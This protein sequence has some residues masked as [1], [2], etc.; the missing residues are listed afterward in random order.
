MPQQT[1]CLPA[2][3]GLNGN[4]A[5]Q[6]GTGIVLGVCWERRHVSA[7]QSDDC[8][9]CRNQSHGPGG[10]QEIVLF[11]LEVSCVLS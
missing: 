8:C 7:Y 1:L 9:A 10:N 5:Q 6:L 3:S 2:A 11:L 4:F